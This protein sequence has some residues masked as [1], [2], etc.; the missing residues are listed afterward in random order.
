MIT[1]HR[2]IEEF[3][4]ALVRTQPVSHEENIR[5]FEALLAHARFLGVLP[6]KDPLEGLEVDIEVARVLNAL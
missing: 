5:I 6:C 3:E 4:N 2:M 1:N